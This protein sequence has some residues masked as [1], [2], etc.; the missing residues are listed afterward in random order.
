[1]NDFKLRISKILISRYTNRWIILCIDLFLSAFAFAFSFWIMQTTYALENSSLPTFYT[2]FV[3]LFLCLITYISLKTHHGVIRYSSYHEIGRII[4]AVFISNLLFYLFLQLIYPHHL[5]GILFSLLIKIS[6]FTFFSL[7]IFRYIIFRIYHYITASS[8]ENNRSAGLMFGIDA[9][10]V[11]IAQM[12]NNN[13]QSPYKIT[14]FITPDSNACNQRILDLP[15]F[16]A[17]KD[18]LQSIIHSYKVTS[19]IFSTQN[20]LLEEKDRLVQAGILLNLQI[21]LARSPKI[22]T[23][24]KKDKH[25]IRPIQIEDLLGRTEIKIDLL[26]IQHDIKG[27]N[28]LV[29]GAAGSI[30]SE[31]VRQIAG[32]EPKT[33]IL[34]DIAETPLYEI[35]TYL[36]DHCRDINIIP[37]IGDVKRNECM[38]KLFRQYHPEIIYHA[39]AYKHVPMMERHP[40]EAILTNVFGTKNVAGCALKYNAEKFVMISTDKAVNPSNVMGASKRI[41]EIYV[42]SLA[43]HIDPKKSTTQFITTRFGNVLGSNGSVIPRFKEQIEAGGPVTVTDKNI[44]R[45]FMTI[46]EACRLVLQAS[47]H[48]ENGEIYLFDMGKPVKIDDLARNMIQLA[49]FIPG[50]DI[51]IVY[52][53]LRPGEKLYEELLNNQEITKP[54]THP[55]IMVAQVAE[56]RFE[57]VSQRIEELIAL[58]YEMKTIQV[59]QKM[60][61][62]VPEFLSLNSIYEQLDQKK[63]VETP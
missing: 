42:Q 5:S 17:K 47:V 49:G 8:H 19:L 10:S 6:T 1:M 15:I 40:S 53:G 2:L 35:E 62:L 63:M 58:A 3:Y 52:T 60:K 16:F 22:W 7:I 57:E 34:F 54:T 18:S 36:S 27:K 11:A 31:I 41:A 21:L 30:G 32:F 43:K 9:D 25:S 12:L 13:R 51:E 45:Y 50:K 4:T 24:E 61:D 29:T 44:I 28:I 39:A 14:G 56:F 37:V 48:G 59:V 55:K 26:D 38:E 20:D 46:P 23:E 33:I